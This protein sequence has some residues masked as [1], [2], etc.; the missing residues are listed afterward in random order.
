MR[1][2]LRGSF[3]VTLTCNRLVYCE[4]TTSML[5]RSASMISMVSSLRVSLLLSTSRGRT[6]NSMKSCALA[7]PSNPGTRGGAANSGSLASSSLSTTRFRTLGAT[8]TA[9][10]L[11]MALVEGRNGATIASL[12]TRSSRLSTIRAVVA[13]YCGRF[14]SNSTSAKITPAMAPSASNRM[15]R[16][17]IRKTPRISRLDCAKPCSITS[18]PLQASAIARLGKNFVVATPL[19]RHGPRGIAPAGCDAYLVPY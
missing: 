13:V 8:I 18:P 4:G 19:R 15:C 3:E 14:T 2:A 11:A 9:A 5:W 16:R 7:V 6:P 10:S 1:A 17:S 12:R